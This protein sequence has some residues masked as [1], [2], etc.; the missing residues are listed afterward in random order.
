MIY[1]TNNRKAVQNAK[2][3]DNCRQNTDFQT[4]E[5]LKD[6]KNRL[7]PKWEAARKHNTTMTKCQLFYQNKLT[8]FLSAHGTILNII[9]INIY[10]AT[11]RANIVLIRK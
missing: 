9:S 4:I 5:G 1:H 6:K 10:T 7:L 8:R 11:S 3:K 2:Q